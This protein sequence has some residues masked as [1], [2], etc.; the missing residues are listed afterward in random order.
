MK[1]ILTVIFGILL[2]VFPMTA[3]KEKEPS[4]DPNKPLLRAYDHCSIASP[5]EEIDFAL[6][7]DFDELTAKLKELF[8]DGDLTAGDFCNE[9]LFED[10]IVLFIYVALDG[11]RCRVVYE[12]FSFDGYFVRLDSV[13]YWYVNTTAETHLDLVVVPKPLNPVSAEA[14]YHWLIEIVK[15]ANAYFGND[16]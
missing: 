10:N 4:F 16:E 7:T 2:F 9:Q 15:P 8:P 14:N 5:T 12:D 11:T 13:Q 1:K 3:C 6:V